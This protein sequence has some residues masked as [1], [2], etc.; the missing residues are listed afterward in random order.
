[1]GCAESKTVSGGGLKGIR[2]GDEGWAETITWTDDSGAKRKAKVSTLPGWRWGMHLAKVPHPKDWTESL[3]QVLER[4]IVSNGLIA[5][6]DDIVCTPQENEKL[7]GIDGLVDLDA[8][9]AGD[10]EGFLDAF[11]ASL[12]RLV[13]MEARLFE[14]QGEESPSEGT[15]S[16][17]V[18]HGIDRELTITQARMFALSE[19]EHM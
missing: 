13:A 8:I 7:N 12:A 15:F 9:A 17:S 18:P 10:N 2:A 1:M 14:V 6:D 19:H 3:W 4:L 11:H 16:S 5:L